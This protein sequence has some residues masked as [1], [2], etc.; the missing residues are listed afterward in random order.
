M[1]LMPRLSLTARLTLLFA[2]GA[3]F[4]L[5][6][7][8]LLI[9]MAIEHHFSQ[10]DMHVLH[11]KLALAE[12]IIE[13]ADSPAAIGQLAGQLQ[14]AFVGHHDLVLFVRGPDGAT[15]L[16]T[17]GVDFPADWLAAATTGSLNLAVWHSGGHRYR[18]MA[19]AFATRVP[20]QPPVVVAVAVDI[21]YHE[22]FMIEF[23]R[24]L[25]LFVGGAML[26]SGLI[27]WLA[28]SRGLAPLRAMR[29]RAG[30]V[31]AQR[32]DQRL[33]V[34]SVPPE[35]ADLAR[36][37]NEMLGRLE[38]A[39]QR[40]S[41]FSSDIAHELRT[42]ISNL[43]MQT[44]VSLSRNR[45]A[46]DYR[47]VLESNAEE[48]ERLARMISDML[49][50]AKADNGLALAKREAVDLAQQLHD[51]FDFYEA[52]AEDRGVR[53]ELEGE[54]TVTGDPLMLRRALGNLL[55]NAL[56]HTAPGAAVRVTLASEGSQLVVTVENPGETIPAAQLPFLFERFY[57]V[58]PSRQHG[59]GEGTGLGLAI[60]R[61]I[62]AAHRGTI[63]VASAEGLT[64]F[65][66]SLPRTP[67]DGPAR[68]GTN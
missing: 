65:V 30:T 59:H 10:Q 8:G 60:T 44:Q 13:R 32:L 14:D 3:G 36:T 5:L 19:T 62:V 53:L 6:A 20:G 50:L 58:D 56:R 26:L 55:S 24:T 1:R 33:P 28:A 39:F 46:A 49:F 2:A 11:G 64:R 47:E 42:P 37:L 51:L 22:A 7:L 9:A 35:L 41:D 27:G 23:R 52:L 61:A 17:P 25:W 18:G 68:A 48:Y 31:T 57:R 54:G 34:D 66:L 38:E 4:V 29:E 16:A 15:L 21:A 67:A 63:S 40:L 43:M 12:N 45:D